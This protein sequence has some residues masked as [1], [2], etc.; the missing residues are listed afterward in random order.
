MDAMEI[1]KFLC[2]LRALQSLCRIN[3]EI[4]ALLF[5][6]GQDGRNNK[7]SMSVFKVKY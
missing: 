5:I 7:G 6:C 1:N 2:R 4:A 3:H